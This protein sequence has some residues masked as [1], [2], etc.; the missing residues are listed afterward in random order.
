M[1][2]QPYRLVKSTT[3]DSFYMTTTTTKNTNKNRVKLIEEFKGAFPQTCGVQ[4]QW[5][6]ETDNS[7]ENNTQKLLNFPN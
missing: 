3:L 5:L 4:G 7:P 2:H 1:Q 6:V